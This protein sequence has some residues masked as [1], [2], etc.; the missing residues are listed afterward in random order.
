M[1]HQNTN[2]LIHEKSPYLLQHAHNPVD[3]YPWG[4]EAFEAAKREDKPVFLSIGYSTCHW[5]HVMEKES[6][7]NEET[8]RILNH[9][10]ISVKVD[11][12]ERPDV[13]AVYMAVCVGMTGSGGWPMTVMMTPEQKP[14][15][16]G[17]YL[18]KHSR[19]GMTG[20]DALLTKTADLWQNSKH[21]LTD[22]AEKVTAYFRDSHTEEEG[23]D[24]P[25]Q[26]LFI[27]AAD[28]LKESFDDKNGGFGSAPKFPA[29]HNLLFLMKYAEK[30]KD[31]EALHA[32]EKTLVQMYRGG[33]FD[34]IGGG[35]SRYSTDK[36]WLVPHFEKMLYDNALLILAYTHAFEITRNALYKTVA[37]KTIG[38]ILRELTHESGGFFCGQDADSDGV[39][40]KYYIFK[41]EEIK[42]VLGDTDGELFCRHFD[43][44]DK[45]NF[46]GNSIPN[47]LKNPDY[48][49]RDSHIDDLC[50]KLYAYRL[51]RTALHKD[52]KILVSWN[53][54]MITALAYAYRVY[55]TEAYLNAAQKAHRFIETSLIRQD[56]RL[57][58]R[59]REGEATGEGKIDDYAFYA[60]ALLELYHSTFSVD[61]LKKACDISEVMY[62]HFFDEENG[63]FYLY[64]DDG[65]QLI[66]RP[67][68][69]F[70]NA[71]PSGNSVSAYVMQRLFSLTA[72]EK[73]RKRLDR[74]MGFLATRIKSYPSGFSFALYT[75]MNELYPHENLVCVTSEKDI[76]QKIILHLSENRRRDTD[77]IVKTA[78]NSEE[79]QKLA[80]FTGEYNIPEN[81]TMY[82]FCHNGTC[83]APV[84]EI[85]KV[86]KQS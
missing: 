1:E 53:A 22:S 40:G 63:G 56:G 15:F 16:A 13:D 86:F 18:P 68:E 30:E 50:A 8:A 11:R 10:F 64:A 32:A 5:C 65:E 36:K 73:W 69:F 29:A 14:F 26:A 38:Y 47:L 6:F 83:K 41:P 43:V 12:E 58:V 52:D 78:E 7:E 33:I 85:E 70:D 45:G 54:L 81:G 39:E 3:W 62:R 74:Q 84:S 66:S 31:R 75:M 60:W 77:I 24:E 17:T 28:A 42:A 48:K 51:N 25:S 34:H 59:W 72:E 19:Y 79:L 23:F 67:K 35:F 20:L 9:N 2:R 76:A 61:Y 55:G 21:T 4:Q 71:M 49:K 37:E 44:T 82:Y 46:E 80:P 57:M 27:S